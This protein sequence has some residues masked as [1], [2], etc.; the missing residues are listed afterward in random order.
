M[1][2]VQLLTVNRSLG[3]VRDEPTR[4][5][6]TDR[7]RLPRFNRN[8]PPVIEVEVSVQP[9]AASPPVAQSLFEYSGRRVREKQGAS[10][11]RS[12][13]GLT[14]GD[15]AAPKPASMR[16]PAERGAW[17]GTGP[18]F[19]RSARPPLASPN[20][21]GEAAIK[22]MP[23]PV[24][25]QEAEPKPV[26]VAAPLSKV[27]PPGLLARWFARRNPFAQRRRSRKG[28]TATQGELALDAVTPLRNDLH[29][30]DIEVVTL[31]PVRAAA[32]KQR[33]TPPDRLAANASVWGWVTSRLFGGGRAG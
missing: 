22:A 1:G 4:Y 19:S 29:D 25:F 13:P 16:A 11:Q 7:T 18:L 9:K 27:R 10:S 24:R 21:T 6:M 5:R 26:P 20:A 30:S 23:E 2:L 8:H 33:P 31:R 15:H 12:L 14:D 3:G 17:K 28:R 32:D